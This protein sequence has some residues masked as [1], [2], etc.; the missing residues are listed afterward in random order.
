MNIRVIDSPE[1][2]L[3]KRLEEVKDYDWEE[4]YPICLSDSDIIVDIYYIDIEI[5]PNA[6]YDESSDCYRYKD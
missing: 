5:T 6:V 4:C 3:G 1:E 2:V